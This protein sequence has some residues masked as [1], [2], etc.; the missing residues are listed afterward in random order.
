MSLSQFLMMP[1]PSK[2][3]ANATLHFIAAGNDPFNLVLV[4]LNTQGKL[5]NVVKSK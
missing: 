5:N 1:P 3:N 4:T 2:S